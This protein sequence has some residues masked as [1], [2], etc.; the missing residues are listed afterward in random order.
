[1]DANGEFMG[2]WARFLCFPLAA[3]ACLKGRF[4][5]VL[6]CWGGGIGEGGG[7]E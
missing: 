2:R 5:G 3:G 4:Y 1:M 7:A 6:V